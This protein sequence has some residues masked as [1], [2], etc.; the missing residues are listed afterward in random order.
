MAMLWRPIVVPS[1]EK[2]GLTWIWIFFFLVSRHVLICLFFSCSYRLGTPA[3]NW[4]EYNCKRQLLGFGCTI[5]FHFF[6]SSWTIFFYMLSNHIFPHYLD[7]HLG[8]P[9]A[10]WR[11][12]QIEINNQCIGLCCRR[13]HNL[14][15]PSRMMGKGGRF[16]CKYLMELKELPGKG[17]KKIE[18]LRSGTKSQ[19]MA[20]WSRWS[21]CLTSNLGV[22]LAYAMRMKNDSCFWL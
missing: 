13:S 21:N 9:S 7:P 17:K 3:F 6:I 15:S 12:L 11:Q 2:L 8:S 4:T 16:S 20:W 1:K 10:S 22:V 18:R 19:G 14:G 5:P